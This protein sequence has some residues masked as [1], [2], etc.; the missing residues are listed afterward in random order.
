[1]RI[2]LRF[3]FSVLLII[4]FAYIFMNGPIILGYPL[5]LLLLGLFLEMAINK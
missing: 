1:M 5:I 4:A 3:I 2:F